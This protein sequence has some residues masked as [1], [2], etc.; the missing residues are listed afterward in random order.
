MFFDA[1]IGIQNYALMQK[2]ESNV[3]VL[4]T[5]DFDHVIVYNKN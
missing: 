1:Q 5:I 2:T 4:K 3:W